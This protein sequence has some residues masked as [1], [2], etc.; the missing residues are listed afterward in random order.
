MYLLVLGPI[1]LPVN[2]RATL[3]SH[4]V[5]G[6]LSI[7]YA[8]QNAS[9]ILERKKKRLERNK[10][11]LARNKTRGGNLLLSGT[12]VTCKKPDTCNDCSSAVEINRIVQHK[13]HVCIDA[14]IVHSIHIEQISNIGSDNSKYK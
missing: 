6:F 9:V 13:I 3:I 5:T 2:C 12:D 7:T 4:T 11:R 14:L 10:T 8:I 1:D